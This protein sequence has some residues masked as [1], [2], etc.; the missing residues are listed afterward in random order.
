LNLPDDEEYI[1]SRVLSLLYI[2]DYVDEDVNALTSA[3]ETEQVSE[4][5]MSFLTQAKIELAT[6]LRA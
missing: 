6:L 1:F 2:G 4:T 3:A 5:W